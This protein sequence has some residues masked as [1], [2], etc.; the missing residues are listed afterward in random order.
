MPEL[1]DVLGAVYNGV[2][3][4]DAPDDPTPETDAKPD[5]PSAA[6]EVTAPEWADE[7]RLD[8][9]FASWRP[10]P[11]RNAPAAERKLFAGADQP[12]ATAT[13][14]LAP[15][16]TPDEAVRRPLDRDM[17][18]ALSEALATQPAAVDPRP[19]FIAPAPAE[20]AAEV[21]KRFESVPSSI[22]APVSYD[23]ADAR[24]L[25]AAGEWHRGSD[26]ILPGKRSRF[27]LRRG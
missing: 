13:D 18:T 22:T 5:S 23:D 1:S 16:P 15:L 6:R 17:A 21:P 7:S 9:A 14:T 27:A 11:D 2:Y 19:E 8:A 4:G 3:G 10:G 24:V 26:D 20:H 25:V 12:A